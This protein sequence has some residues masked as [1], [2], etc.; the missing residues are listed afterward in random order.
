MNVQQA[1]LM[2]AVGYSIYNMDAIRPAQHLLKDLDKQ[3]AKA[4]FI[5]ATLRN[6]ADGIIK[7]TLAASRT[8]PNPRYIGH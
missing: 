3:V 2:Q 7:A 5:P 8:W 1:H 6:L 4:V